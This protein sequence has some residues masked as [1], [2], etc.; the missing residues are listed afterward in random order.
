M[1]SILVLGVSTVI[2]RATLEHLQAGGYEVVRT[3]PTPTSNNLTL[4]MAMLAEPVPVG[5][6]AGPRDNDR[7]YL[8]R[9]KGRS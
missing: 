7:P 4:S 5:P 2:S 6:Y 9:K 8:K 1:S 3:T